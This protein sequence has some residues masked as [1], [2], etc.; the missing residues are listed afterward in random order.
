MQYQVP[1][2][3]FTFIKKVILLHGQKRRHLC[4]LLRVPVKKDYIYIVSEDLKFCRT[5]FYASSGDSQNISDFLA[6]E[7][8]Y[9]RP[10]FWPHQ[11]PLPLPGWQASLLACN[12]IQTCR[13]CVTEKT[14]QFIYQLEDRAPIL[15]RLWSPGIDSKELIPPA[16]VAWRAGTITLFLLGS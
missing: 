8:G 1:A 5:L 10:E 12:K 3:D 7:R 11:Q 14:N 15:K 2:Y 9:H 6:W 4:I 13:L 16:N